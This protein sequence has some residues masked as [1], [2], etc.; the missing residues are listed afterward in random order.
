MRKKGHF[1]MKISSSII[2]KETRAS[3]A[4]GGCSLIIFTNS[5]DKATSMI[6]PERRVFSWLPAG[7]AGV[8]SNAGGLT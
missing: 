4:A 3:R 8:E 7:R 2:S 1:G 5:G 6:P